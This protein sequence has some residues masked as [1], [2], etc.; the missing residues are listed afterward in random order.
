MKN[1]RIA[2][3]GAGF[4]GI[5]MGIE[6]QR[7]GYSDF[8]IFEGSTEIGGVWRDNKYPGVACDVPSVLYSY[9]FEQNYTW[10][11]RYAPGIEI[12]SYLENCARKYGISDKICFGHK[13]KTAKFDEKKR[14]WNLDFVGHNTFPAD[15]LISAMGLFNRP[16][17]PNLTGLDQFQGESFH[18]SKWNHDIDLYGKRVAVVGTGASAIQ[19]VPEIAPIIGSL[20]IFQRSAQYVTPKIAS[21]R[22]DHFDSSITLEQRQE[23]R[24]EIYEEMVNNSDRRYS[25]EKTRHVQDG[26]IEYLKTVVPNDELRSHLTP[27]YPFGCK[28]VLRS[29]DWYP[30]LSRNNVELIPHE[31]TKILPD[32]LAAGGHEYKD[33]D[34]IIYNTGFRTTEYLSPVNLV[35]T[36]GMSLRELWKDGAE[37]FLGMT[38]SGFPN[39]FMM[40]GPNTNLS[41]S[42]IFMLECQARYIGEAITT[43]DRDQKTSLEVLKKKQESFNA[44]I[45]KRLNESTMTTANCLSYFQTE[46][47]KIVTQWP[48]STEAY[49]QAT[50]N[51]NTSDFIWK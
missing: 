25:I 26:F 9:S 11:K 30:A 44:T 33:I 13:L 47:G 50:A 20:L 4:G 15:I 5:A 40:Y 6:L 31:V 37:A 43:L 24:R 34:V 22:E 8:K 29:D 23:E 27:D 35:G 10:S 51:F 19:F 21:R 42:I 14:S 3:I 39:F 41:G 48:G 2:I 45:Q 16:R 1:R 7:A 38:V 49:A 36:N 18:S 12:K 32:G 28:R 46:T 17:L